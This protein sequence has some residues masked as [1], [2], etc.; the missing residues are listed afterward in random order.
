MFDRGHDFTGQDLKNKS[1][2]ELDLRNCRFVDCDLRGADFTRAN[3]SFADLTGANLDG[4]KMLGAIMHETVGAFRNGGPII[5]VVG[6]QYPV[7]I[8]GVFITF[9]CATI[10]HTGKTGLDHDTLLKLDKKKGFCFYALGKELLQ[11][12]RNNNP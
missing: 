3:L 12:Y 7:L 6:L 9:G 5:S 2:R 1:F 10:E 4:A 11:W 8:D